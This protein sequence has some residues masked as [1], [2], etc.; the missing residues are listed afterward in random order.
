MKNDEKRASAKLLKKLK[1]NKIAITYEDTY[2]SLLRHEKFER[3]A[4]ENSDD[5]ID[6]TDL[7]QLKLA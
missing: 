5:F 2:Q 7:Y 1:S 3:K 6:L 4:L